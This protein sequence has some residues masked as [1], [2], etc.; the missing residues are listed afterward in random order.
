[1]KYCLY[2]EGIMKHVLL[3]A[4]LKDE[5]ETCLIKCLSK[6]WIIKYAYLKDGNEIMP[7]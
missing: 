5:N 3:N 1:M 6:G 7:I 4:Y 2:K